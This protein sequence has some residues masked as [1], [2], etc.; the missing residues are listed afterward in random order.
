MEND[1]EREGKG[2]EEILPRE[3]DDD[4]TTAKVAVGNRHDKIIVSSF[5]SSVSSQ[6]P[7]PAERKLAA[8]TLEQP[9]NK[10]RM[11]EETID[12][13]DERST[14]HAIAMETTDQLP[15]TDCTSPCVGCIRGAFAELVFAH[16]H[17]CDRKKNDGH[18]NDSS[19]AGL[20]QLSAI[21]ATEPADEAPEERASGAPAQ[22]SCEQALSAERLIYKL[23]FGFRG[24]ARRAKETTKLNHSK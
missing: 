10:I 18:T 14:T 6:P 17:F 5:L 7:E 19:C 12:T 24:C 16:D 3:K 23:Y 20:R 1:D 21:L 2:S 22:R 4:E 8:A 11:N 9:G 15:V 13:P